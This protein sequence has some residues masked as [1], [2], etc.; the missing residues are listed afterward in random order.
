MTRETRTDAARRW[1]LS[2]AL[3]LWRGTGVDRDG[4]GVWEA[5]DHDAK[6]LTTMNKRFR[7]PIR[8]AFVFATAA[9][10]LGTDDGPLAAKLFAQSM[11]DGVAADTGALAALHA[12]DGT[13]LSAPHD[14]YDL[15]FVILADASLQAGG[16]TPE[17]DL[18]PLLDRLKVDRGWRENLFGRIGPRR[19]NPHM[20]LFEAALAQVAAGDER[21]RPIAEECLSLLHDVFL[22]PDGSLFEYFDDDW[23]P[24]ATGQRVEPGHMA[25]WVYLL[26]YYHRVTGKETGVDIDQLF[27]QARAAR[28]ENG[29]LPD[30]TMPDV[31]TQRFWPQTELLKAAL[32]QERRGA[33][34]PDMADAIFDQIFATYLATPVR[35][36]WFDQFDAE[37]ALISG[38][39]PA[40]TGYHIMLAL[41]WFCEVREA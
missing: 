40:S 39:M 24:V 41:L 2:D 29:F 26:D 13:I 3:P 5:L 30:A 34:G 38:N 16:H 32:V 35:G 22:Q 12:P 33:V 17:T 4:F 27:A 6:P 8:Q 1:L 11:A 19:Q 20:H 18:M 37:G 7:V 36:G 10:V 15:A 25:E 31:P 23:V 28:A 21:Y 9:Q 14:L